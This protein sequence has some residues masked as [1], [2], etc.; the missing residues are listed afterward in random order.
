MQTKSVQ[1]LGGVIFFIGVILGLVLSLAAIWGAFEGISYYYTGAGY[2][3]FNGLDCPMLMTRSETGTVTASFDNP[4]DQ[5]I[6]PYYEVTI[7]GQTSMRKFEGQLSVP[8][9]TSKRIRWKV[10]ANDIDLGFFI[11]INMDVLPVAGFTTREVTCGIIVLNLA[12]PT[13]GQVF[14]LALAVSLMGIGIGLGLWE[15][16][17]SMK[18]DN[19][20][21]LRRAVKTLGIT[22]LLTLLT[23]IMGWWLAGLLFCVLTILLLVIILRLFIESL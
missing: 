17:A 14:N 7:S 12:G 21:N 3:S 6:E 23:S 11:F 15:N 9:H 10:D 2:P 22:V 16:A 4:S 20:L 5:E 1:T 19:S 18:F 8:A 13:G